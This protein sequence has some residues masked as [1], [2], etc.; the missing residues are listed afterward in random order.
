MIIAYLGSI[1]L[2]RNST[3]LRFGQRKTAKAAAII[4]LKLNNHF[5]LRLPPRYARFL[6]K[7]KVDNC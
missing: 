3:P 4:Q 5:F 6:R 2:L 1:P 7:R